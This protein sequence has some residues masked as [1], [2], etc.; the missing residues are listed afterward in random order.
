MNV[1]TF[2]EFVT[3]KNQYRANNKETENFN[4]YFKILYKKIK[5]LSF[6]VSEKE[7]RLKILSHQQTHLTHCIRRDG[8]FQKARVFL[9]LFI[10]LFIY[11][12]FRQKYNFISF[13]TVFKSDFLYLKSENKSN[14]KRSQFGIGVSVFDKEKCIFFSI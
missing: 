3:C 5:N 1:R 12:W 7:I 2:D 10:T 13:H 9:L 8:V 6:V 4:N 14:W 11:K